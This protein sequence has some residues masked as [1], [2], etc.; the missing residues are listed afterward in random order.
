[1]L[2][3]CLIFLAWVIL[4]G[5]AIHLIRKYINSSKQDREKQFR[6]M[7]EV[8]F[9]IPLTAFFIVGGIL[10]NLGFGNDTVYPV[11][12]IGFL[13]TIFIP[14]FELLVYY[15]LKRETREKFNDPSTYKLPGLYK[16]RMI[17]L[18][19]VLG[20]AVIGIIIMIYQ[21]AELAF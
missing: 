6:L 8:V 15:L 9:A 17:F 12:F 5:I 16:Y 20:F 7:L 21:C 11:M 19:L 4:L 18:P 10:R 14:G 13:V 2:K 1:M 3:L